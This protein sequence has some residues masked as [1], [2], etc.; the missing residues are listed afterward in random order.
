MGV[1]VSRNILD[2][3]EPLN[4]LKPV[5]PD[6][7]IADGPQVLFNYFH[8]MKIPFSTRMTVVKLKTGDLWVHSPISLTPDL[9]AEIV[10]LGPVRALI[11]SNQIHTT[12]LADWQAAFPDAAIFAAPGSAKRLAQAGAAAKKDLGA[13]AEALWR[14]EIDQLV[15]QG[16]YM[17]EVEFFHRPTRTLIL[18][19]LIEN[20]EPSRIHSRFW[21]VMM[22]WFQAA[23]PDGSLT[24]DLR[25]TF[26][27]KYRAGLKDA[28]E[29]MISWQPERIVISH[30]RWYEK[31]GVA[32][33][34]R[35]FRWLLD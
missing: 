22:K 21:R 23:D 30:G 2:L 29:T 24:K 19:D 7:W 28:V 11:S 17:A 16:S 8:L 25:A 15:I 18:T 13:G 27:G 32:E 6:V 12:W 9:K 26:G 35:A 14:G 3:Y 5:A 31:D 33:L 1:S 34:R 4:T 20:F 10:A